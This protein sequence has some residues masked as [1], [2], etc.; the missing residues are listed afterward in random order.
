MTDDE[1]A[2]LDPSARDFAVRWLGLSDDERDRFCRQ[3]LAAIDV[4]QR[5][6]FLDPAAAGG[7]DLASA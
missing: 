6:G 3:L 2:A 1:F 4:L 7:E 5:L